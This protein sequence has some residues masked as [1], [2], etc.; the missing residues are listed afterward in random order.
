M[1]DGLTIDQEDRGKE[2]PCFDRETHA[3]LRGKIGGVEVELELVAERLEH[4]LCVIAKM[5]LVLREQGHALHP[6]H[7]P[8]VGAHPRDDNNC[9]R[10]LTLCSRSAMRH[11]RRAQAQRAPAS[12]G[13]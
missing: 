5:A 7:A 13:C 2:E 1:E 8:S 10:I 9:S 11:S 6:M 4:S 12:A 3:P